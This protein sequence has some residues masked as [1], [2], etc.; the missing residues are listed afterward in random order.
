ME[1]AKTAS[2][3]IGRIAYGV[4]SLSLMLISFIMIGVALWDIWN[5][6]QERNKLIPALLDAIGFIVI[7][8]AVFDVSKFLLEEEVFG[9]DRKESPSEERARLTR[10]LMIIT[11]AISLEALVFIFNAA[12]TDISTLIYPTFLLLADILMVLSLGLYHKLTHEAPP[13]AV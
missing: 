2:T 1:N 5:T 3:I 7:A 6:I 12:K 13:T 10:F 8:M 11:I 4:V 9:A